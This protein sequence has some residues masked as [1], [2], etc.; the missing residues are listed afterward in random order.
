MRYAKRAH[1]PA[2]PFAVFDERGNPA[3]DRVQDY[4]ASALAAA[5]ARAE[6]AEA[7]LERERIRLAACG[8]VAL[9]NTPESAAKQRVMHPDYRSASCDDVARAVDREMDLQAEAARLRAALAEL[10]ACKDLI[11]SIEHADMGDPAEEAVLAE[12][13][14]RKPL[15]WAA[16]RK[17]LAAQPQQ[18]PTR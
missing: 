4:A 11:D 14:R 13:A 2:C 17:A 7:E 12:Y 5:Q 3:D 10:V 16:A 18:E 9:S 1:I 15:A 8:V 6:A